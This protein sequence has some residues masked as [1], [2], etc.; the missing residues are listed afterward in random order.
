MTAIPSLPCSTYRL[1]FHEEFRFQ[2]ATRLLPYLS[3]LGITHVYASP[4]F[5]AGPHSRHGYDICDHNE[6]NPE[7]GTQEDFDGFVSALHEHN[8]GLIL[9]FVPNHMGIA[10]QRNPWWWDVLENGHASA[11][12]RY[13]DIE[14]QPLKT[15]MENKV[16]L[17]ILGDQYGRVLEGGQ[18]KIQFSNGAFSLHYYGTVLPLDPKSTR[19]ILRRAGEQMN[20]VPDE[21]ESILTALDNLPSL[22]ESDAARITERGRE[23]GIIR[24]RLTRLCATDPAV[25]EAI[26]ATLS[27]W[28]DSSAGG[29]AHDRLDALLSVQAYRLSYWRVAAEEIN[30]RR[31]FD[32]NTLAAICVELPEV[33]D[34]THRLLLQLVSEGKVNGVRIDHIDGLALPLAYLETLRDRLA[35]ASGGTPYLVVEKIL[36]KDESLPAAWPIHGTTGYEFA[37]GCTAVLVDGAAGPLFTG[38]YTKFLGFVLSYP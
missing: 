33:F 29:A 37:A 28:C 10:D 4:I 21:L 11:F 36:G 27:E 18:L 12:A 24:E 17:P 1:Q 8:M 6:L 23:K 35:E 31:F 30:Y 3:E 26:N 22:N 7:I 9:D 14:W 19:V 16:L 15:A 2:D 25:N 32:I 5:R 13:F 20:P 34:A 38:L